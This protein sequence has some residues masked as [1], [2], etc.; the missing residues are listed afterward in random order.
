MR[1]TVNPQLHN[2]VFPWDFLKESY[3]TTTKTMIMPPQN[4]QTE[5]LLNLDKSSTLN[6]EQTKTSGEKSIPYQ[7]RTQTSKDWSVRI[8]RNS[9]TFDLFYLRHQ[10]CYSSI[11]KKQLPLLD[12]KPSAIHLRY[13]QG[14]IPHLQ[15]RNLRLCQSIWCFPFGLMSLF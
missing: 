6:A 3:K 5:N 15:I 9:I 11:E 1:F 14:N 7:A 12:Y 13:Y 2:V 10:S 8:L 4:L